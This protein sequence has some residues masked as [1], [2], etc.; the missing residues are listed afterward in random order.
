[1]NIPPFFND[2]YVDDK[3][4]LTSAQQIFN[5]QL[6]QAMQSDLS[7]NGWQL[8]NQTTANINT[9]APVMKN[10]TMW[11]DTDTNEFKVLI[12]GVVKVV[13]VS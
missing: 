1:M 8:P 12:N 10:G 6:N 2:K 5:D 7:D 13:T 9:I 11:Y 3:G 4:Y